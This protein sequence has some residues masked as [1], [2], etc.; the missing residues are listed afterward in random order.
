MAFKLAVISDIHNAEP[1]RF[2]SAMPA[3]PDYV[4]VGSVRLVPFVD[5]EEPDCNARRSDAHS[6]YA[7]GDF[8]PHTCGCCATAA[9]TV[10]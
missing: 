5:A 3:P 4:A 6:P 2:Y 8:A 1:H 9:T 7:I 10:T